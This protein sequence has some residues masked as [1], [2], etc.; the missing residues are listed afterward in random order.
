MP[1]TRAIAGPLGSANAR[2]ASLCGCRR[3]SRNRNY[4][5]AFAF[6]VIPLLLLFASKWF[7]TVSLAADD[8]SAPMSVFEM[9]GLETAGTWLGIAA[10]ILQSA[11]FSGLNLAVFSLS[12]LRLQI[13]ADGGDRDAARVLELRKHANQILATIVWGNVSTNVLLT[14]LSNS[15]LAGLVAFIFSA[16]AITLLGEIFPQAYFSRNALAMTARFLPFLQFYRFVLFPLAKPTAMLL[17]WWLG[18]EGILYMRERDIRQAIG[19]HVAA[20]GEISKLEATGA[21]NFLDLD[22]VPVCD[23]GEVVHTESILSL[24]IANQRCVLP[25]FRPAPDDP[26]LRQ[27]DASGMKW[28]IVTDTLGEPAFVLD[29]HHFLRD[30]LFN[31]LEKDPTAYWHR[32]I[33][34]RDPRTRLG[35]VIGL[36]KVMPERS[37][38]DVID[39]DL[40]LVWS[41]ERRI[42]TGADLLGRLLRGITQVEPRPAAKVVTTG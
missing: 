30:A 18:A 5:R 37:G 32:P 36:M 17:D 25:S 42:I 4:F 39:H 22:D 33:I 10:C 16:F 7:A 14:L 9:F 13:A 27:V 26:F 31:Q 29:A 23:E 21:Q 11:L 41:T 1:I 12:M 34:V 3:A 6:G 15:V 20:G 35:E 38:D 24:P 28:V 40:I 8:A 19:S 2:K